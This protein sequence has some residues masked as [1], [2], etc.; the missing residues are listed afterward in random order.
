MS[1][2]KTARPS[3]TVELG[4]ARHQFSSLKSKLDFISAGNSW[5]NMPVNIGLTHM[6][7][8]ALPYFSFR[9]SW[10]LY[11]GIKISKTKHRNPNTLG[12]KFQIF[13]WIPKIWVILSTVKPFV[14][15]FENLGQIW[16]SF[17]SNNSNNKFG[18]Y[19]RFYGSLYGQVRQIFSHFF[20]NIKIFL[21]KKN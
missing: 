14:L 2:E 5:L 17:L 3:W 21:A 6:A 19:E 15:Y 12:V 8:T 16:S 4:S 1:W 9:I 7:S 13:P 11:Q 18:W 10:A 20:L